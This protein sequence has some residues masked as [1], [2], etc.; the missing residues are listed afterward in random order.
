MVAMQERKKTQ[1]V[2][3]IIRVLYMFVKHVVDIQALFLQG[4]WEKFAILSLIYESMGHREMS[5]K[6]HKWMYR[7]VEPLLLGSWIEKNKLRK[8]TQV[9]YIIFNF[10]CERL[11]PY[12]LE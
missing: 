9:K 5:I 1:F 3:R 12:V 11:N 2:F 7:F 4:E 10:L 6:S 8:R